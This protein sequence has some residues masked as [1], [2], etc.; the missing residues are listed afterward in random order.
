MK[1]HMILCKHN[2]RTATPTTQTQSVTA[3][4][5]G[6]LTPRQLPSIIIEEKGEKCKN[7]ASQ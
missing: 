6:N 7:H 5:L 4:M 1:H 3:Q 2:K